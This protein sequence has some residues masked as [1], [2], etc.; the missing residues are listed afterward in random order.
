MQNIFQ[1]LLSSFVFALR[2]SGSAAVLIFFGVGCKVMQPRPLPAIMPAPAQY[3][4]AADTAG[5]RLVFKE[6][7]PDTCLAGLVDSA[8]A[9]NTDLAIAL[10]RV[11][12]A[13]ARLGM[14]RGALLPSVDAVISGGAERYGDYT[15]NGVGNFDTNLSPNIDGD[16]KIPVSPATDLWAGVRSS[17]EIDLWGKLRHLSR[18]AQ[19]ALLSGREG[20]QWLMTGV[21]AGITRGY[22]TLLGY[23]RELGIVRHN[24]GLQEAALEIVRAQKAGGRANELA[25]QQFKAQLLNTRA[26]EY[27]IMQERVKTENELNAMAGRYPQPIARDTSLPVAVTTLI[28]AGLPSTLL[29]GRPDIRQAEYELQAARENVQA[30]RAAF[31][32]SLVISPY[33]ALNAFS[34][35]LLVNA[36]SMAY[37]ITG[38]LTAPIFRQRA[39]RAG[40]SIAYAS[41]REAVYRYQQKLLDAYGEVMTQM[42]AVK[43]LQQANDITGQEVHE[44]QLAVITSRDLYLAGYASYL[45]VI[46]AQKNVLEA[47]LRLAAQ[48]RDI[49]IALVQL[50]RS[51]GGGWE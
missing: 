34:P 29:S 50:Y 6:L 31:L 3:G 35:A 7:F 1:Q 27:R 45:E 4:P 10:E 14:R 39:L 46:T 47:E 42:S 41:N 37:G 15:M 32:P 21:V 25:V 5:R 18:A 30:A 22:Y 33:V 44:L 20:R 51:L 49:S 12:A 16:R 8:L 28:H 43:N 24:I 9:H 23:D 48:K 19:A 36:A 17:W 13:E 38:G 40:Y 26:I 2:Y 11:A